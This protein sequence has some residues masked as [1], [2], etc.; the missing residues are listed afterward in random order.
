MA[1]AEL[2]GLAT[3][4]PALSSWESE[5]CSLAVVGMAL[6]SSLASESA[7][8]RNEIKHLSCHLITT[9]RL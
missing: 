6:Y 8:Y 5:D 4:D 3:V 9:D 7:T 2:C 1:G